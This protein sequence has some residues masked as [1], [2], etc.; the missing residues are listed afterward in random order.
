ML[1]YLN[2]IKI[3]VLLTFVYFLT[4]FDRRKKVHLWV[5]GILLINVLK[6][7]VS[8]YLRYA[9]IGLTFTSTFYVILHTTAW[10]GLLGLI[11]QRVVAA[12]ILMA[13]FL[14]FAIVNLLAIE[15]T[16]AFNGLT[17]VVGAFC[18]VGFFIADCYNRLRRED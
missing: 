6:E 10:I 15:G 7:L 9:G 17:L 1:Q 3:L 18:Y 5:F 16:V 8:I 4:K 11:A 12:R 14:S 13:V 2:P